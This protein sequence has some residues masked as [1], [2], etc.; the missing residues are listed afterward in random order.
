MI[1]SLILSS[2]WISTDRLM[3]QIK[4]GTKKICGRQ[5]LKNLKEYSLLGNFTWSILEYF[6]SYSAVSFYCCDVFYPFYSVSLNAFFLCA[7][8]LYFPFQVQ[9]SKE[10]SRKVPFDIY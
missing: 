6:V 4:N 9:P 7:V 10:T 8:A 2:R 5:P 3:E 1:V